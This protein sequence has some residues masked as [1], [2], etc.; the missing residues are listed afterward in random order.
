MNNPIT[1]FETSSTRYD[2]LLLLWEASVRSTHHFL[3]EE[4]IQYFKP[5]IRSSY[6]QAVQLY[7]IENEKKQIVAFMGLSED[8]IEM[9]FVHPGEQG[10]GYGKRLI[11]FAIQSKQICK[12]D[13]NE[14]NETAYRFYLNRGFEVVGRDETDSTG[15]PYPIFHMQLPP[16]RYLPY[17]RK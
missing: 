12:V 1:P 3:K 7:I 8:M 11:E 9:L 6:F 2:E 4:D 10:K 15:K 13:V 16:V 14:Q 17:I 5:L